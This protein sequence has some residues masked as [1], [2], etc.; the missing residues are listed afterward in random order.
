M[1]PFTD[2]LLGFSPFPTATAHCNFLDCTLT[3]TEIWICR[4]A[5]SSVKVPVYTSPVHCSS[6]PPLLRSIESNRPQPKVLYD[7]AL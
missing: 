3:L 7:F 2:A 6:A 5:A 4:R 1:G